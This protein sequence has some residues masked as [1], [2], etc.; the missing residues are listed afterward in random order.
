MA[1]EESI[2]I[3]PN[4]AYREATKLLDKV[5]GNLHK[6]LWKAEQSQTKYHV[7]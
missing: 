3:P 4:E 7:P 2:K 6:I 5:Y 1:L